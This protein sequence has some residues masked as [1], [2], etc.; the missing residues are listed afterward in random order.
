MGSAPSFHRGMALPSHSL[1]SS[2]SAFLLCTL[3]S[4]NEPWTTEPALACKVIPPGQTL[5]A[6]VGAVVAGQAGAVK[7][8]ARTRNLQ[9]REGLITAEYP[10]RRVLKTG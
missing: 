8:A 3:S 7:R 4:S 10:G 6:G 9:G 5:R 2:G 1:F